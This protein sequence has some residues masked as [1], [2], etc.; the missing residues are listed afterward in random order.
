MKKLLLTI[1]LLIPITTFAGLSDGLV[2]YWPLDRRD[3]TLT[4][5]TTGTA[6]DRSGSNAPGRILN[7][8]SISTALSRGK[9][10]QTLNFDGSNDRV[11][12]P[13]SAATGSLGTV[14]A[15]VNTSL[16]AGTQQSILTSSGTT[17]LAHEWRFSINN[18]GCGYLCITI[19]ENN[20]GTANVI[21]GTTQIVLNRWY[22]LAVTS[23]GSRYLFY[24][25]GVP[26]AIT[27]QQGTNTGNWFSDISSRVNYQIGM[28]TR[29]ADVIPFKGYID[30][31]RVYNR[32]LSQSEI[33][34]IYRLGLVRKWLPF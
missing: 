21:R 30:E 3:M 22:H 33:N 23:N 4:S 27:V 11:S 25:N 34:N 2:G 16:A 1:L 7:F 29:T 10:G 13:V 15:W 14:T 9:I 32:E 19:V 8:A 17:D 12:M 6:F 20:G 28:L 31:V 5:D 18:T 26:E 24:V